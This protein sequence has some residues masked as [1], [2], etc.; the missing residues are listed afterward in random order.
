MDW[1]AA[2]TKARNTVRQAAGAAG[3][4]VR[5]LPAPPKP[6]LPN[7]SVP[8][9]TKKAVQKTAPLLKPV[10]RAVT[11]PLLKPITRAATSAQGRATV[12]GFAKPVL[13]TLPFTEN[14]KG[15]LK[16]VKYRPLIA[17]SGNRSVSGE[18]TGRGVDVHNA[19]V[20]NPIFQKLPQTAKRLVVNNPVTNILRKFDPP[21]IELGADR[22][23][24]PSA[25]STLTH[26]SLHHLFE[27]S[28]MGSKNKDPNDRINKTA[29]WLKA[30]NQA[31]K[32][33]TVHSALQKIDDKLKKSRAYNT[34]DPHSVA[35]ERYA[36]LGQLVARNGIESIPAPLRSF[37][38]GYVE[39]IEG[40][41]V[42]DFE[43]RAP[44]NKVRT[45][46]KSIPE[47]IRDMA[48]VN[49]GIIKEGVGK[50]GA[51]GAKV[52]PGIPMFI[53][54]VKK[55]DLRPY[56]SHIK[57]SLPGNRSLIRHDE[58]GK[59]LR[60]E[61]GKLVLDEEEYAKFENLVG[62]FT[63]NGMRKVTDPLLKSAAQVTQKAAAP[64]FKGFDDLTTRT[65]EKLK[66]RSTVSKQFISDI[67]NS[68]DLKQAERD[69]VRR[70]L[71]DERDTVNVPDFANKVKSELL[72]LESNVKIPGDRGGLSAQYES[73]TLPD[74]LRGP[75]ANYSERI[76]ESPIKTSAGEVHFQERKHP[77]YFAHSRIEDLPDK[78]TRRVIEAQSDLFQKGRLEDEVGGTMGNVYSPEE[79]SRG[80]VA[81]DPMVKQ[82]GLR[83][84]NSTSFGTKK[85]METLRDGILARA[86]EIKKLEPYRN[87]WHE[88]VIREEVKQAAKD[89]KTKLQFPTGETA[90]K[91]EGLGQGGEQGFLLLGDEMPT[92]GW[93]TE[94]PLTPGNMEVGRVITDRSNDDWIITDVLGDGKFKAVPK[95]T[96]DNFMELGGIEDDVARRN[97]EANA[98][99][100]DISGKVDT[101][102]PI[103]R[104]Y[105]KEVGR[106][107]VN[108][109]GAKRI[110]D[111]QGVEWWELPVKK[112]LRNAPVEAYGVGA[113][114]EIDDEG[115]V[116]FDPA[117]AA[118]GV[119]GAGIAKRTGASDKLNELIAKGLARVVARGKRSVVQIKRGDRWV[120][121]PSV[122]EA[123]KTPLLKKPL[124]PSQDLPRLKFDE[125]G[126]PLAY[127]PREK[128]ILTGSTS[129]KASTLPPHPPKPLP[130]SKGS[131]PSL[132]EIIEQTPVKN[133]ANII[134]KLRTPDRVLKKFGMEK[135]AKL[136]RTS[137]D[138]YLK[139]L[140]KNIDKITE[141]SGRVGKL[142]SRNIFRY[143]DGQPITLAPREQEV[144]DEI[145]VWL[146]QWAD[147]LGLPAENRI[148]NYIT[149]LFEDQ[150]IQREF[151]EDLAKIIA[152]KIPG[153][154]YNPFLQKRL[155]TMG[156]KE[157]VWKALD[158]Y[159]KRATRKVH[160]DPAL[161]RLEVAGQQLEESQ[162]RYVK[163]Y[164][165]R[166]NMRPTEIDTLIDNFVK[167]T[168]IGYR[169]SQRPTARGTQ[170]VRRAVYRAFLG[171]NPGSALRNLS[172]G[173]N[174]YSKL[175]EKH[176]VLGYVKLFSPE[177]R[178]ELVEEGV[179]GNGF[180][181]DRVMTAT[182]KAWERLDKG[183]FFFFDSA[184]KVNR[185]AAYLGAKSKALSKGMSEKDAVE[186]AKEIVRKT[187]FNYDVVD[188]PAFLQSDIAKTLLQLGT[189][190]TK[191]TEFLAE[192]LKNKELAGLARYAGAGLLFVY[193]IGRA[194]G[195]EPKEL[196]PITHET[197]G[198]FG[199]PAALK[200]PWEGVKAVLDTPDKYGND[201]TP[202]EHLKHVSEAFFTSYFPGGTQL[203]KSFE[204]T[205]AAMEGGSFTKSGNLQFEVGGSPFKNAQ[206]VVFGKHANREAKTYFGNLKKGEEEKDAGK[207]LYEEV[208]KLNE[209][210][211]KDEAQSLVDSFSD[212][213]YELFKKARTDARRERAQAG[214]KDMLPVYNEVKRLNAIGDKTGAQ[215]LVD[216]LTDDQYASYK[217][218]KK[219]VTER[220]DPS[221]T[222]H[223][224]VLNY[225]RAFGVDPAN[226]FKALITD[227]KLGDVE[228]KLV[229]LQRGKG[230]PFNAA[231]GTEDMIREEL[232]R[233]G[234]PESERGS[235][236]YEHIVPVGAGGDNARSNFMVVTSGIHDLWTK[237]DTKL[238]A[239]VRG[240]RL[241]RRKAA[242]IAK[243]MKSGQIT[244]EEALAQIP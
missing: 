223:T 161:E 206:A 183:L 231:G 107:L 97:Y 134:D 198:R 54:G 212:E 164:A 106:Y 39:G 67:T 34:G 14:A 178:K 173:A 55:N 234:I 58:D 207:A 16:S 238:S 181:Q 15:L 169:L 112:E 98:E 52:A 31:K 167:S 244:L 135:E 27:Q 151:D 10:T 64:V 133:K 129:P 65:L 1:G 224:L 222:F 108:K 95:A 230:I 191:Q 146:K 171:L 111:A 99:T 123:V 91:I 214:V 110:K 176:T 59:P 208:R 47:G 21:N 186:F 83:V 46:V 86:E 216:G 78:K 100:F 142:S 76:Y 42:N 144:A 152:D 40:R 126:M 211:R 92:G 19:I 228:G 187:Q 25:R 104:F 219:Q 24:K 68:P 69:V 37:Y 201:R 38:A 155:G 103:Y 145:H 177:A 124:P 242:E 225:T 189:Y 239:S 115:N 41:A 232:E 102:N 150:I 209:E 18:Y 154:V 138:A 29:D 153:S 94:T 20:K 75:V 166:I 200:A 2:L 128:R 109:Y 235:Y 4:A 57:G 184:E 221:P 125:S 51:A 192:M 43:S 53:E 127:T 36:Y 188:T 6:L 182:K 197:F 149:H 193:T 139:E 82:W 233:M 12:K 159:V 32:D 132:P 13:N 116:S 96:H 147:R 77:N 240:G 114:I 130:N 60:D 17:D 204:G 237:F 30:W 243:K 179:L 165:D 226:A 203:K 148:A 210:G 85:E 199:T 119:A 241:S 26:E 175:G 87:T 50:V 180:V 202:E 196:L 143:L 63:G 236:N 89:G 5:A 170:A 131:V 217:L 117:K 113:G 105:E 66:G 185:G 158:A 70:V 156:Y 121:A 28:P 137:Y 93:G 174:V 80:V 140:P 11:S 88:R 71:A 194:F 3:N 56:L 162:W 8:L 49:A 163:K 136:L 61:N 141:W 79:I 73:I 84:G 7:P 23:E 118:L 35:T 122:E 45:F 172:Q 101:E 160:M 157:D 22:L 72:P 81:Y 227:E 218:A 229:Q 90:M 168:P 213:D 120:T 9:L 220:S 205:K 33:P 62:G 74:E 48:K 215:E 190:P 44:D 195:M